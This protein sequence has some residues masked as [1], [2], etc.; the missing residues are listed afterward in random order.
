MLCVET[1]FFYGP[2][3][4]VLCPISYAILCSA[5]TASFFVWPF[6]MD[7]W[8]HLVKLNREVFA[9]QNVDGNAL[10]KKRADIF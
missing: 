9:D 2:D 5:A 4:L 10:V 8:L 6:A 1:M 3:C 7:G